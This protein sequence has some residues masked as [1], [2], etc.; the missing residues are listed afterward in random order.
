VSA[1]STAARSTNRCTLN[2]AIPSRDKGWWALSWEGAPNNG[3]SSCRVARGIQTRSDK[4]ALH[5]PKR[6]LD[7]S[8]VDDT[9]EP[10]RPMRCPRQN[11]AR[12][13]TAYAAA[14]RIPEE[15]ANKSIRRTTDACSARGQANLRRFA[16]ARSNIVA[17]L[18]I[19]NPSV[20][21]A[22]RNQPPCFALF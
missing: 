6:K 17:P 13:G 21:H 20:N 1:A 2:D 7:V 10:E 9:S 4:T 22:E 11:S 18:W 3:A 8:H 12:R 19:G 5:P 16:N 14:F 15:Q